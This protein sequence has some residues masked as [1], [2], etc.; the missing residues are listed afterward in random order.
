MASAVEAFGSAPDVVV[1]GAA[2]NFLCKAADLS[3]NGFKAVVDTDLIGTC[4]VFKAA[5]FHLRRPGDK[6]EIA[7]LAVFLSFSAPAW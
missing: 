2:V 4:N 7:D 6:D 1:S 5:C 3:P